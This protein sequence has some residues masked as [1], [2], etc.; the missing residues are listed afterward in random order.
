MICSAKDT[1]G[2][3]C[4]NEG[5]TCCSDRSISCELMRRKLFRIDLPLPD[6]KDA[7]SSKATS[8]LLVLRFFLTQLSEL[9]LFLVLP[10]RVLVAEKELRRELAFGRKEMGRLKPGDLDFLIV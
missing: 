1:E 6:V 2:D 8:S 9:N 10:A 4:F 3:S 5:P 7:A